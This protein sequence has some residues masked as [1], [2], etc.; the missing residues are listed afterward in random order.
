MQNMKL[1]KSLL[2][3]AVGC[4]SVSACSLPF[5]GAPDGGGM[6]GPHTCVVAAADA[7]AVDPVSTVM[8]T[9]DVENVV[10]AM[11]CPPPG[12]TTANPN[13]IDKYSQGY[14]YADP[15][16]LAKLNPTMGS[17]SVH[18]EMLQMGGMPYGTSSAKNYTNTQRSQDTS[19]IRGFRY[20]DAS[21]GVNLGEDLNG[22]HPG[23]VAD[24]QN[25]GYATA[26]P[27]SMARGAAFDLD[28][29]YAVGEAIG[30]EMQAVGET[31]LLAPCMNLLRHPYWGRGQE[32]YGEDPYQIGRLASAMVV[33]IQ[34]H[35]AANAKHYMGYDVE[36]GRQTNV[37]IM[38]EQTLREIYGRHF[39]MVVQDSGVASVMASYNS[40]GE[41][42]ALAQKSTINRHTLTDILR[43]DFGFKGFVLSDWWAVPGADNILDAATQTSTAKSLFNAGLDVELPWL[44][45]YSN[46]QS[47][48]STGSVTKPDLDAAV[49]R[50][51]YEKY[52]FN[53]DK[54]TG[55]VGL[56]QPVTIYDQTKG[57]ITCD[58]THLALAK[59]AALE[60]MVLL[61]NNGVLPISP[62]VKN[63]AVVGATLPYTVQTGT[64]SV[65][66]ATDVRGGDLG[67]SRVYPDPA[68][69]VGP[70]AGFC[71]ASGG[72]VVGADGKPA[73]AGTNCSGG[74][75]N[76]TTATNTTSGDLSAVMSAVS[77]A[78]FVVVMAG[79]TPQDEGE[80]YTDA[81]DRV[82]K[83]INPGACLE[84]D[85][86]Q[87]S[88]AYQ[89]IQDKLIAQVAA[90][91]KP[92]VVVLEGGSV[93][94]VPWLSQVPALVMAWYPGQRGGEA[95]PDLLWGQVGGVSYN[96]G[97]KLPFTW[98][99]EQQYGDPFDPTG[100]TTTFDYY[101]GYRYFD[102]NKITPV[103]PFGA[104]LS[105]TTFALSNV[106]LGCS[107]M[108]QGAVL[109]VVVN[110]QNTGTVAGDDT[111]M[112]F[113]SF[114]QTQARRSPK[115]LKGFA[116]VSLA[117][118][119]AKQVTIPVRLSDLD[120]FQ[121]DSPT[122]TTGH[123]V[124]ETGPVNIMVT[125]GSQNSS[126][127]TVF[128][129]TQTVN[130]AGYVG[131]SQ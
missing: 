3:T 11:A 43:T 21:R 8:A 22:T 123:W 110:V 71:T 4:L 89:G 30:D 112:V 120:Y 62:A 104:G 23:N 69:S 36:A 28:L 42:V 38:D 95:L 14:D 109:P 99:L 84:L 81:A 26:F 9:G 97:G 50:I 31:L 103:F 108:A 53:A 65:N 116:R 34:E 92:M 131:P 122:A 90:S 76:V 39:R 107:S 128:L 19:T 119:E 70:F 88:A 73:P 83:C 86:K 100:G 68:K 105:Y 15:Q 49:S 18:D 126:G 121:Q 125:D 29:E 46:I 72:T 101:V 45:N 32:T 24:G 1:L 127:A 44:Y 33:G 2:W 63:L 61:K 118:G 75:V 10:T 27:V 41:S 6:M 7:G 20:R 80:E 91:G 58:S 25:V 48:N 54:L 57:A 115:E 82:T 35:V 13:A 124:V 96:F 129:P 78:D 5:P 16:V 56:K 67:S 40:V 77:A 79:L 52:R 55:S 87:A 51:L 117:A 85:A 113:V 12:S 64:L 102:E 66:F 47:L 98:G 93:I 37:S 130:V 74:S 17:I 59:R 60:S 106:Q 111:V 114:P 94:N